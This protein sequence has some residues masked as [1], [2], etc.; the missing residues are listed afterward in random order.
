MRRICELYTVYLAKCSNWFKIDQNYINTKIHTIGANMRWICEILPECTQF[1]WLSAPYGVKIP[2]WA[3]MRWICEILPECTQFILLSDMQKEAI[4]SNFLRKSSVTRMMNTS[5]HA[6]RSS[7]EKLRVTMLN[8]VQRF[9]NTD[10]E[11]ESLK[12]HAKF[13]SQ[14]STLGLKFNVFSKNQR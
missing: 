11:I 7:A 8:F 13:E 3:N 14:N 6:K 4:P 1:I 9:L 2:N 12:Q 5:T 10:L